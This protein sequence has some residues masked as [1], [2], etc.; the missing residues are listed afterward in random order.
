M[1]RLI[2]ILCLF[3]CSCHQ[4]TGKD[5]DTIPGQCIKSDNGNPFYPYYH[6]V[7][8]RDDNIFCYLQTHVGLGYYYGNPDCSM[9]GGRHRHKNCKCVDGNKAYRHPVTGTTLRLSLILENPN[10][11]RVW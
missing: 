7:F 4:L 2:L 9:V 1:M 6:L 5:L 8:Y 3:V 11:L 10:M